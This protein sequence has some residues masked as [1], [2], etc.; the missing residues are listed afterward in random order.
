MSKSQIT[1]SELRQ[2][3]MSEVRKFPECENV[4]SVEI[5]RE[6]GSS[7]DVAAVVRDGAYFSPAYLRVLEIAGNFRG[8]Y[9]LA[10]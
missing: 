2:L 9:D 7:W 5:T 4:T 1:E 10:A 6:T 8:Q 3:L